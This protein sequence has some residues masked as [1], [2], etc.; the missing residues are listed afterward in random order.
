MA[1]LVARPP[2]D[3]KV[4]GSNPGASKA[5]AQTANTNIRRQ[6]SKLDHIVTV[7]HMAINNHEKSLR[8]CSACCN[9][10]NGGKV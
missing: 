8:H 7:Q 6:A 5:S 9:P 2:T 3:P 10:S 4:R 1:D